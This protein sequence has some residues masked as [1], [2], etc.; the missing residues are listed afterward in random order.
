ME[1]G[2]VPAHSIKESAMAD[3]K[4]SALNALTTADD[5]DLFVVV[6]TSAT[7]TKKITKANMLSPIV[8]S[9]ANVGIGTAT[10]VAQLGVYGAGQTTGAMSTST[11]LGGMLYVRD[12]GDLYGNGGSVL[13]GAGQGSFAA[14]KGFLTDGSNNT[15]GDLLFSTR[16]ATTD[17]TLT[18]HLRITAIG[19]VGIGT[20]SPRAP[21]HIQ[22][23]GS[24]SDDFNVLVSQYRPNIVL[25]D[26]NTSVTDYQLFV[27]NDLQFRYGDA[28]TDTKLANEAMRID[29]SGNVGIGTTSPSS[30][31]KF[32]ATGGKA[33]TN[34]S[35]AAF[36]TAG[37]GQG[38]DVDIALYSTFEGTADNTPRRTAD[39]V[40]GYNG[41]AWGNEY[42][43]FNV[44]NNGSSNDARLLTSEKVRIT[45][46]GNVLVGQTTTTVPGLSNTTQG[47]AWSSNGT[48]LHLS[49]DSNAV[50]WF[51]RN[52]T[53]GDIQSFRYN[54]S[55]VGSI[56]VTASATAY[57]TS[58]DYRLKENV[59]GL[60]GAIDRV[61][62]LKPSRFNFIVDP[63][64]T[65]DGFV[66]HEV[67]DI[68]PEA[69]H[70]A[71]DAVDADGNPEYQGIDQSKLVPL[72]TAALQEALAKIDALEARV[73]ALETV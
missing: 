27:D 14:I 13:F 34:T 43:S 48:S 61:K 40:A 28:S 65:V 70:G 7:E 16:N 54:G 56:S 73:A 71:K 12:S 41:G 57:N 35:S 23:S 53:T 29:S 60:S 6:D 50:A 1:R 3:A 52:A 69:V 44:G 68:V 47:G 46:S 72:L 33:G 15:T 55:A 67:S 31:G 19:R 62:L 51:N 36:S 49:R 39:I 42:L 58:S 26:L 38:E 11:G 10:P 4:I 20:T 8:I 66:A 45:G 24:A 63:D 2:F 30:Q 17:S 5:A 25:E 21:L 22:P 9:G 18:E 37:A 32:V 59:I 64:T